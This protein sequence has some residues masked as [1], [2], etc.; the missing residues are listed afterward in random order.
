[1]AK[2]KDLVEVTVKIPKGTYGKLLVTS[3]DEGIPVDDLVTEAVE[4]H[5]EPEE[6]PE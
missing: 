6:N 1:M 2:A 4:D 5:L 3:E